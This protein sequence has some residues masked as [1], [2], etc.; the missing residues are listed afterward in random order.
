MTKLFVLIVC[1]V[2]GC[3]PM[4]QYPIMDADFAEH[5]A[6]LLN[7]SDVYTCQFIVVDNKIYTENGDLINPALFLEDIKGNYISGKAYTQKTK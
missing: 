5:I 4:F 2:I 7:E 3:Q 6:R 1:G